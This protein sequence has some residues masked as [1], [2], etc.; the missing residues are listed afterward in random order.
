MTEYEGRSISPYNTIETNIYLD[1]LFVCISQHS[2]LFCPAFI[3]LFQ[4]IQKVLYQKVLKMYLCF[5]DGVVFRYFFMLGK[6]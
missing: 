6:K 2:H 1:D 4:I 3:Q 5:G